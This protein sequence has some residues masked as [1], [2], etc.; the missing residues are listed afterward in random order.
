MLMRE[1]AGGRS[2]RK[3]GAGGLASERIRTAGKL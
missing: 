1:K 3:H 2:E